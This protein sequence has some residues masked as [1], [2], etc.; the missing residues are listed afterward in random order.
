MAVTAPPLPNNTQPKPAE[1]PVVEK[2]RGRK[3]K[4]P[5]AAPSE[6]TF[7]TPP[8]THEKLSV[9]LPVSIVQ[10][11]RNYLGGDV[12]IQELVIRDMTDRGLLVF[13]PE[14]EAQ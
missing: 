3:P 13:N 1:L 12:Y 14:F 7:P 4:D 6:S 10:G 9:R 2:K 5:N 8:A 11:I